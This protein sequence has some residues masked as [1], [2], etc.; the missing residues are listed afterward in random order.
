[1]PV[2]DTAQSDPVGTNISTVTISA[3]ASGVAPTVETAKATSGTWFMIDI[4]NTSNS[5]DAYVKAWD[6]AGGATVTLGSTSPEGVVLVRGGGRTSYSCSGGTAFSAGMKVCAVT[7]G[8]T[9]GTTG[10]TGDVVVRILYS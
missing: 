2:V 4:D 7:T 3:P 1:M 6:V 9:A 10:M 8:G 5:S